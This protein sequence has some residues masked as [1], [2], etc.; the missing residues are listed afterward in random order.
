MLQRGFLYWYYRVFYR[1]VWLFSILMRVWA[2]L[3]GIPPLTDLLGLS[4][5]G[6]SMWVLVLCVA[7]YVA[8]HFLSKGMRFLLREQEKGF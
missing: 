7:F 1:V 8:G 6:H 5:W 3:L 4:D 2:V